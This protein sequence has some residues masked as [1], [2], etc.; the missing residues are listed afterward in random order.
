MSNKKIG[1]KIA[2]I[3]IAVAVAFTACKSMPEAVKSAKAEVEKLIPGKELAAWKGE[4][5]SVDVVKN[6]P[7]LKEL[8][9]EAASKNSNYTQEGIKDAIEGRR[10]TPFARVKFDGTNKISFT[11]IDADGKQKE[12]VAEYKYLGKVPMPGYEGSFWETFEAVKNVRGL[13]MAKYM[14]CTHP[15]SHDGGQVHW[16]VR[17]GGTN[18]D[19]LV[20]KADPSYWPTYVDGST[21]NEK[22]LENFKKSIESSAAKLPA[23]FAVYAKEGKWMNS[24]LIY[25]NTSAEVNAAY[26]KI[27][28]EFAG[29]NPKGGDFTKAEII[30]E[31]KKA[32]GTTELYTHIEFVTENGK[33]EFVMYKDGK[34]IYRAAYKRVAENAAKPGLL[35]VKTDKKD[36]GMFKTISLTSA[37]GSPAHFHFWY[38]MTDADFA[39][40][41]EKPTCIPANLSNEMIAKRVEGS[42][43]KILSGLIQK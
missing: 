7:S 29:K 24:S 2:L 4:W 26:D 25:D 17:F 10:K 20:K 3:L 22:L 11:V 9:K 30:A 27:I 31:M 37:G 41:K 14:I 6:D 42:C 35:A 1:A 8:Y 32:Y 13:T 23:P 5:V 16:H 21:S 36:A 28:K 38:G 39:K 12:I 18:I 34:E 33:N 19:T 40:I 43:R 15:H